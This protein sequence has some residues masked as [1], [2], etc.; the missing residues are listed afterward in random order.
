MQISWLTDRPLS[1]QFK[2]R[3]E[4]HVPDRVPCLEP[5]PGGTYPR[6]RTGALERSWRPEID[7]VK[8]YTRQHLQ[9]KTGII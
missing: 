9:N 3:S 1:R 2:T 6:W 4:E 8:C 7:S 5:R